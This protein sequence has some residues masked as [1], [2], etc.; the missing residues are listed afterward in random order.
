M[1]PFEEFYWLAVGAWS[2]TRP[3]SNN[4]PFQMISI[5]MFATKLIDFEAAYGH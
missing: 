5:N 2:L 4:P 3:A 1:R